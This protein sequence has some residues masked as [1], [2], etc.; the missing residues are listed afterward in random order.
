MI[1]SGT[2]ILNESGLFD[3]DLTFVAE[4]I[5]FIILALFVTSHL[6]LNN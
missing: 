6:L 3:F 4:A 2:F 1:F 5:L